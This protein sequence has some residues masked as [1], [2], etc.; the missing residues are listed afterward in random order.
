MKHSDMQLPMKKA[1][2]KIEH[3]KEELQS[4]KSK[5]DRY[6]QSIEEETHVGEA[7]D[8]SSPKTT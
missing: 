5:T 7:A 1:L 6:V 3:L 4:K 8:W 2:I